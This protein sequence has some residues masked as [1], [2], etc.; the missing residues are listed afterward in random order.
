M[1]IHVVTAAP[2]QVYPSLKDFFEREKLPVASIDMKYFRWKDSSFFD[3]FAKSD[4]I[5]RPSIEAL[6]QKFPKR[7]FT[8]I[9]DSG[10]GDAELYAD[11]F[12]KYPQQ[13]EKIWIRNASLGASPPPS[14]VELPKDRWAF[15]SD[16]K[17][18]LK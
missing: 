9:G 2:W 6:L 14:L 11:L 13:I 10:E 15:F 18:L 3:L 1:A 16:A 4:E 8:F 12:H 17:E 5:K 7:K